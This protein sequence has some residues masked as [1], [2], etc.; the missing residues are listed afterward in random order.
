MSEFKTLANP[1]KFESFDVRTAV[2]SDNNVW[3]CAKD[4]CAILDIVWTG[5]TI[6]LDNMPESWFMV[7]NLMTIKGERDT[8]FINES[9]LYWLVKQR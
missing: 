3:F 8:Y 4:V 6:T 9:G 2:D 5:A 7:M 1:F